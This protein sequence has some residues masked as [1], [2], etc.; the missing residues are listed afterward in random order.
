M[1]QMAPTAIGAA[2]TGLWR[3]QQ[4]L[5]SVQT[6]LCPLG[7]STIGRKNWMFAGSKGGGKAM[8]I[9]LILI[10]TADGRSCVSRISISQL[11]RYSAAPSF[12]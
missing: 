10:E 11:F 7:R 12:G 9:A 3:T 6:P 1:R 5:C 8:A 4:L 2:E